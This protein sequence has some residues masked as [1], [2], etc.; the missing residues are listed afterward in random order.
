MA[1]PPPTCTVGAGT[2]AV[3]PLLVA[4]PGGGI[5][6]AYWTASGLD[7]LDAA[8]PGSLFAVSGVSGGSV[9]ATAWTYARAVAGD[10]EPVSGRQTVA[11]LARDEMLA[12]GVA[13][14][15]ARDVPASLF[16]L[17][18]PFVDRATVSERVMERQLA[19]AT[20]RPP[21]QGDL[22][23][24]ELAGDPG[25]DPAL[26]LNAASATQG[27]R[28]LM[29]TVGGLTGPPAA[30]GQDVPPG[31]RARGSP[32]HPMP[33]PSCRA[34]SRPPTVCSPAPPGSD[35]PARWTTRR[36]CG[37]PPP[38]CCRRGSPSADPAGA[39][40]RCV[41]GVV[42]PSYV[43]DGGY[44]EN[45]GLLTLLQVWEEIEPS[46]EDYNDTA[47]VRV[48]P[49]VIVLDNHYRSV[50]G[51]APVDRVPELVL[52]F[53]AFNQ[54]RN[55]LSTAALEQVAA[56]EMDG[57]LCHVSPRTRPSVAAPLGWVLSRTTRAEL[58][59]QLA[60]ALGPPSPPGVPPAWMTGSS[61][62]PT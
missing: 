9:G 45:S 62:C 42:T 55:T 2:E 3:R 30:Q 16:A 47:N 33:D 44:V 18:D 6:A 4:A 52:P 22:S 29:T 60:A 36:R 15:L 37:P 51:G 43:V 11:A 14:L 50:A 5:R 61:L 40:R 35:R 59:E 57:R 8:C 20:G 46:V 34:R 17:N 13:A 23:L 41:G 21:G 26:V 48:E 38:P 28:V 12:A 31:A 58:D 7:R 49:W 56:R 53:L 27:C 10:G 25:A 19:Q 39:L 24:D 32:S 54:A 1:G